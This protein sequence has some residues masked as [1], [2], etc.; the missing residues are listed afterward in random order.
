MIQIRNGVFETNSS[1]THSLSLSDFQ[2][3]KNG[4]CYFDDRRVK[5][6]PSLSKND[7]LKDHPEVRRSDLYTFE[8][9]FDEHALHMFA[10]F[11]DAEIEEDEEK[12]DDDFFDKWL[13]ENK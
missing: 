13:K 9:Y 2:L 4:L 3:W 6:T 7:Y 12:D 1:S 8:D 11:V 5:F 10:N